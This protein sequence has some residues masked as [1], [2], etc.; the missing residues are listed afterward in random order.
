MTD[1]I[2]I[3]AFVDIAGN[4][5]ATKER[6]CA[7]SERILKVRKLHN[8]MKRYREEFP[9]FLKLEDSHSSVMQGRRRN[10]LEEF[11]EE[12][13]ETGYVIIKQEEI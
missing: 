2:S 8:Q 10:I 1:C 4:M 5:H 9:R 3:E 7:A 12:L 11:L 13:I 6:C